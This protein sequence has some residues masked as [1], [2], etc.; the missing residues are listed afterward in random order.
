M[1][2]GLL[3]RRNVKADANARV[4]RQALALV[5]DTAHESANAAA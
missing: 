5:L 1:G 4:L 3:L 2:G